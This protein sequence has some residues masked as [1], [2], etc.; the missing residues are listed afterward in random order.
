MGLK[1]TIRFWWIISGTNSFHRHRCV[2][3]INC[4]K[5]RCRRLCS[6]FDTSIA[7]RCQ[8][9]IF[10]CLFVFQVRDHHDFNKSILVL[11]TCERHRLIHTHPDCWNVIWPSIVNV[12]TALVYISSMNNKKECADNTSG[13][14]ETDTNPTMHYTNNPQSNLLTE[15]RTRAHFITK[16]CSVGYG[17]CA[18]WN[19]RIKSIVR[20]FEP[21][22][23]LCQN[24][25]VSNNNYVYRQS[26]VRKPT[27]SGVEWVE[28]SRS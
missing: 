10:S 19:L 11:R 13:T 27:G 17:R 21:L 18:L 7:S 14:L 24:I 6:T 3:L 1:I 5:I 2:Y 16:W 20:D 8:N 15:M 22:A 28:C 9:T 26:Q 4:R 23:C 12:V 25:E